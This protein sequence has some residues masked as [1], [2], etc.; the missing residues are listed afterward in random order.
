M[1]PILLN[2]SYSRIATNQN[3]LWSNFGILVLRR[4]RYDFEA[5]ASWWN[6][7]YD[8]EWFYYDNMN[9]SP[10]YSEFE[11]QYFTNTIEQTKPGK[12]IPRS[13]FP[14]YTSVI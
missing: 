6:P 14:N 8:P 1:T 10:D 5:G 3:E 7:I 9:L 4:N 2:V 13:N 12:T 11:N